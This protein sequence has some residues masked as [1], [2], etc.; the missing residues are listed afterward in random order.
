MDL[1]KIT[2]EIIEASLRA[3]RS[4]AIPRDELLQLSIF[5]QHASSNEER[6]ILLVDF[7]NDQVLKAYRASRLREGLIE[8]LNHDRQAVADQIQ[9]DFGY[10]NVELESWSAL[11]YR[12]IYSIPLSVEELSRMANVVPQQFRRRLTQGLAYLVQAVRRAEMTN[13]QQNARPNVSIPLPEFTRLIGMQAR[14]A[15][16]Q[17]LFADPDGPKLVSL[18]GIGGIGKTVLARAFVA[19][20]QVAGQW[21]R[22]LW[23]SAR[24][25]LLAED[26]RE[27][28]G[29]QPSAT[30]E[31]ITDRLLNQLNL[32]GLAEKPLADRLEG[33]RQA[34]SREASLVVVDN[35]ETVAEYLLLVPALANL[36]GASRFLITTRQ[37]LRDFPYIHTISINELSAAQAY[38][39]IQTENSR[40]GRGFDLSSLRFDDLYAVVGGLPLAL[41]LVTAQL[42]MH[43]LQDI[44][45]G[46]RKA[47][48]GSDR[49]YRYLYWQAWQGLS[50][51]A[52]RLLLAFIPIAPEGEG[53]DFIRLMSGFPD[54]TFFS[55]LAEIDRFSLLEIVSADTGP[56]FRL[57]RLTVTFLQT[58]ILKLW[59]DAEK[60]VP[61]GQ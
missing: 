35:L 45:E 41:K 42:E 54:E 16:L 30:L 36:A 23:V 17:A 21:K 26:G 9:A 47:S 18:E 15:E 20:P 8:P 2:S 29:D 46:Y 40:R 49:L 13:I 12:Y 57:H 14:L 6:A 55:A 4:A 27:T 7:F 31:D 33:L 5:S 25:N 39:L 3:A 22:I 58:N 38:E 60:E 32:G 48:D 28:C 56:L 51:K 10:S 61:D 52:R 53:L 34:L 50:D 19:L 1:S 44:L 59:S 11:Y 24:Q 37:T 43:P